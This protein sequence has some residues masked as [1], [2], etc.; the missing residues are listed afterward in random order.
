MPSDERDRQFERAL[1][2]HLRPDAGEATACP[3]AETLAAYHERAL[4]LEELTKWKGHI[5]GCTRCQETLA[6]LEETN[7]MAL[8]EWEE[9]DVMLQEATA[10]SAGASAPRV[11]S[12][13]NA[14]LGEV[15]DSS[16]GS[17]P[18]SQVRKIVRPKAWRWVV[19]AG[20]LAAG[21]LVFVATKEYR[22]RM[23]TPVSALQVAENRATARPPAMEPPLAPAPT[24]GRDKAQMQKKSQPTLPTI[25]DDTEA[26]ARVG[27]LHARAGTMA[28]AAPKKTPE[29]YSAF[30]AENQNA[31]KLDSTAANSKG[32]EIEPQAK[33]AAPSQS[34]AATISGYANA[35]APQ[36]A[37]RARRSGAG[38]AVGGAPSAAKQNE[39]SAKREKPEAVTETVEV[40]AA[41]PGAP[42]QLT[43]N[44]AQLRRIANV[45]PH[46]I[47]APDGKRAWRIGAVGIIESS[48]DVGLN[49]K[50]QKSE[51]NV[52]LTAGSAPSDRVCWVVGKAG[53]ILLTTD[54]GKH[55][56][57][58]ASPLAEDLGGVHA[59]DAK[60]ASIWNVA[61]QK[62]FETADGG[63]TWTPTANE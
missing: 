61:N 14:R 27:S 39:N 41:P 60:H 32:I 1:Q 36:P 24:A 45:N 49:W 12:A 7:A 29:N 5:S 57:L 21:L 43:M 23:K 18:P 13:V 46:L 30:N 52:D 47:L 44:Y 53:T 2:R 48:S 3:D 37:Q 16:E 4:S 63:M 58:I 8:H 54:G 50:A 20:A 31:N 28:P 35:P 56:K 15:A 38:A 42:A 19:P 26:T 40:Q 33:Q 51:V 6:L 11:A 9:K 22:S 25:G 62:S 55:W 34:S 10:M 59:L 17:S